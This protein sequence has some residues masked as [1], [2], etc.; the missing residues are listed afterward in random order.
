MREIYRNVTVYYIA[1]AVLIGL[2]PLLSWKVFIPN[3]ETNLEESLDQADDARRVITEIIELDPKRLEF[4]QNQD[5]ATEFDFARV[6]TD[7]TSEL[8]IPTNRY[9][10]NISP[11]R[12]S[13]GQKTQTAKLSFEEINIETFARLLATLQM[14]WT[15]LQ[16]TD[17]KV[18]SKKGARDLWDFDITLKYYY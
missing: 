12:R 1:A 5:G 3:A 7:V 17:I 10:P 14:R 4:A 15:S 18:E 6:I 13:K 11:P 8:R 16:C 2:W 9:K